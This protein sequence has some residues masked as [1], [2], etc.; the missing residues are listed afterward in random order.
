MLF[1]CC[2]RFVLLSSF[3]CYAGAARKRNI[4]ASTFLSFLRHSPLVLR[5]FLHDRIAISKCSL[6]RRR[7]RFL[8]GTGGC[9]LSD[10]AGIDRRNR[11]LRRIAGLFPGAGQLIREDSWNTPSRVRVARLLQ[12]IQLRDVRGFRLC[13]CAT[14]SHFDDRGYV[15]RHSLVAVSAGLCAARVLSLLSF[16]G[17]NYILACRARNCPAAF[18]GHIGRIGPHRSHRRDANFSD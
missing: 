17:G 15:R 8:G 12:R 18:A 6:Y 13:P 10:S 9:S 1:L 3:V 11:C 14:V 7:D 16:L 2:S 5:H 4:Q